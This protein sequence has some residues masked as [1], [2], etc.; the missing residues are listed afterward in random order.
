MFSTLPEKFRTH[1]LAADIRT[2]LLLQKAI[3]KNL[4]RT[5]GDIYTV[6]KGIVVKEPQQIGPFTKAFYDYFL[7]IEIKPNESLN[8]AILRSKAFK[9]WRD[10]LQL[11]ENVET[12]DVEELVTKFLDEIH[13][14]SYGIKKILDGKEL[15]N[16]DNPDL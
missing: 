10:N 4:I 11:N 13:L 1:G 8:D 9:N 15:F 6:L 7:G 3:D 5:L 16:N 12:P 14:T 2:L